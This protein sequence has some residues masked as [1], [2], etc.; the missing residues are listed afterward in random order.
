MKAV[1]WASP[2]RS[3]IIL[4]ATLAG[5]SGPLRIP[6]EVKVPVPIA[7]VDP[8]DRP[9]RPEL[10][11]DAELL[12]M[13]YYKRTLALWADR[14]ERQIYQAKLEAVVEGCSNIP[15]IQ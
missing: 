13:D 6:T 1:G 3:A 5:C 9:Q 15:A 4:L 11:T 10:V 12:A 7:C 8:A 2:T 14:I